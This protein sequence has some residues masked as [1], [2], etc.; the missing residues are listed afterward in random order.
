M[1]RI[2]TPSRSEAYLFG[3]AIKLIKASEDLLQETIVNIESNQEFVIYARIKIMSRDAGTLFSITHNQ[4]KLFLL[5]LS[6]KGTG[7]KTKLFLRYRSTNDT[8]E[9]ITFKNVASLGDMKYH[10]I[11]LRITDVVEYGKKFS[12][13]ALYVDCEFFGKAETVSPI[14]AIFSYKGTLLSL[15]G[16]RIA[17][18]GFGDKAPHTK[19]KVC[20]PVSFFF[21]GL[22]QE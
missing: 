2:F 7:E 18:R 21:Y 11:L 10:T 12:A 4:R 1:R 17:S 13:V 8:T 14:S 15:L 9:Y 6:T 5:D 16:F 3:R 19:W 20:R 22:R